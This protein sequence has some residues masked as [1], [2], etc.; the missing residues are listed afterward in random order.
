VPGVGRAIV[1]IDLL[2]ADP[3]PNPRFPRV[4]PP[5]QHSG[6]QLEQ[7]PS[8][9]RPV[10]LVARADLVIERMSAAESTYA[11]VKDPLSLRYF[12]L[13]P[14]Q[15]AVLTWLDGET[16]VVDLRDRLQAEFPG[17]P[18]SV[19]DVQ[20]LVADLHE[21]ALL[22]SSRFDQGAVLIHRADT[23]RWKRLRQALLNPLYLR[24]PGW[25]PE[26][27]LQFLL[28]FLSWMFHPAIVLAVLAFDLTSIGFLCVRFDDVARRMPEFHQ[29]F[30]WPNIA[31]IWLTMA[32]VKVLHEFGHGLACRHFGAECHSMGV[33]VLVFSPTLYCDVSDSWML[34]NKWRRIAIGAAGIYVEVF[35]AGCA[36]FLWWSTY[37][38]LFNH[39]CLNVFF[40]S[41]VT[42]V[43]FNANPLMRYDGYYMLSDYLEIPNLR[44]K[45]S[46]MFRDLFARCCL[47]VE[48]PHD[49]FM[50]SGPRHW[51]AIYAVA[52][53]VY[54]FVILLGVTLFLY[55]VLKP[56][57][58]QSLGITLAAVSLATTCGALLFGL[59]KLVTMPRQEPLS[60]VRV[61][62]TLGIVAIMIIA[63]FRIPVPW[64]AEAPFTVES[65]NPTT[66]YAAVP[67]VLVEVFKQPGENVVRGELI[68]RLRN[69][70]LEEKVRSLAA[71]EAAQMRGI[72]GLRALDRSLELAIAERELEA[73][74]S[75]R[76]E[77]E[78]MQRECEIRAA[79][80][81]VITAAPRQPE[82]SV[83]D[84]RDR[85]G[86]WT[87]TPLEARNL[88]CLIPT[89]TPLCSIAPDDTRRAVLIVD[90]AERRELAAGQMV[91]LKLEHLP[92]L[93]LDGRVESIS[94]RSLEYA[95]ATLSN[96]S[97][98]PLPTVSEP[99]GRER[100]TSTAFQALVPVDVPGHLV[101]T[102]MRGRARVIVANRSAWDWTWRWVRTTFRFR[103]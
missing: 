103:I 23:G 51:F 98:G 27:T 34:K 70:E 82:P 72:D 52:T 41:T 22:I 48:P 81:G 45:A 14:E 68:A 36:I 19:R 43:I 8:S 40:V 1:R 83:E 65:T 56:Y 58:L 76:A 47:G 4:R 5:M 30:G 38:G 50:P 95:P 39:L 26:R 89:K 102:G 100:L 31:L 99:D 33:M 79:V 69:D 64:Y 11:V 42:T 24:L 35:I 90:Q 62:A 20:A 29:F 71:S 16:S 87:G 28:R 2:A 97:G 54:Q 25:D 10:P 61:S 55:T 66:V 21:K 86:G 85:L 37:P 53:T 67:G 13:Q 7:R 60:K 93:V 15:H 6:S 77:A 32:G 57:R 94:N 75:Q 101:R 46:R 88:G 91:R 12:R 96:K 84:R 74:R 9:Q 44:Q 73:I 92:Q 17:A 78:R 3:V 49:P 63:A 80:S 18:V 59:W